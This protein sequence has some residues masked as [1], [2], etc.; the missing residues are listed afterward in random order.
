MTVLIALLVALVT[1]LNFLIAFP[2]LAG[3]WWADFK[4]GYSRRMNE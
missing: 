2:K 4:M 1:Q 3:R